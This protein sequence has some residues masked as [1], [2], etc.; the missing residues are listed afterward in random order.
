MGQYAILQYAILQY[1][2][3]QY[4]ILRFFKKLLTSEKQYFSGE[5]KKI[6]KL[7]FLY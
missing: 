6:F 5:L 2:I 7:Y 1:A 3:L 4:A